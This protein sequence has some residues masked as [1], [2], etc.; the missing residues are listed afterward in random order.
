MEDEDDECNEDIFEQ[1]FI[2]TI[3]LKKVCQGFKPVKSFDEL[4]ENDSFKALFRNIGN[5]IDLEGNAEMGDEEF[6]T[7]FTRDI[8]LM[9]QWCEAMKKNG[10]PKKYI[11]A[12]IDKLANFYITLQRYTGG[13]LHDLDFL[14]VIEVFE[15]WIIKED[16]TPAHIDTYILTLKRFYDSLKKEGVKDIQYELLDE[17]EINDLKR[18]AREFKTGA[19]DGEGED[20]RDWRQRNIHYYM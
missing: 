11:D 8:F 20:Y 19:W 6:A 16:L 2:K 12:L 10:K 3:N 17:E 4:K 14:N 15:V 7:A 13:F 5:D 18:V 1:G 9:T